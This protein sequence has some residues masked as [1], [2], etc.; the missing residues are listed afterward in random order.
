MRCSLYIQVFG[1]RFRLLQIGQSSS[2][3][4]VCFYFY[5]NFNSQKLYLQMLIKRVYLFSCT[6]FSRPR[7]I[8]LDEYGSIYFLAISKRQFFQ[9]FFV[10]DVRLLLISV[11]KVYTVRC[12]IDIMMHCA[13]LKVQHRLCPSCF[14]PLFSAS[15]HHPAQ[16]KVL[17]GC[18]LI[19]SY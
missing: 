16:Q 17:P 12:N 19:C 1:G 8:V 18:T 14:P 13:I 4:P 15:S 10:T 9:V 5:Y 3:Q 7:A 2:Q 6:V 11:P